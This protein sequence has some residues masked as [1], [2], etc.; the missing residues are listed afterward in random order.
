MNVNVRQ[1]RG[2]W[3]IGYSL[4]KHTISSTFIGNNEYGYPQFDTVR[5]ETGEA[6]FQLKNRSDR[7]QVSVIARQ[8]A[9]SLGSYYDSASFIIPML[10]SKQRAIQPV[11]EI[12][13]QVA[14]NMD[15]PCNE[16][17]L[18]KTSI[19]AQMKDISKREDRV[20]TLNSA[21]EVNDILEDD[22]ADV[23]IIDDVYDTG[24]SLIAA[25]NVLRS[26]EKIGNIY[27]ATVTRIK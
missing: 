12:A 21:F 5:T 17:I 10:P 8:L 11:I 9:D 19:T 6:L 16:N 2:P 13:R 23:L 25:T 4:D 26:Y 27:V 22:I 15:I 1:I 20:S 14:I 18:V 7:S 3:D 24:S